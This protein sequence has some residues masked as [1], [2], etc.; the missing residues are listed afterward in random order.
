MWKKSHQAQ[1][2]AKKA[3]VVDTRGCKRH[4]ENEKPNEVAEVASDKKL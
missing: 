3:A 2:K 4:E 1:I